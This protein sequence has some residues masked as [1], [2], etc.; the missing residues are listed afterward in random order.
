MIL[1]HRGGVGKTQIREN[2]LQAFDR[3]ME[4]AHIDGI[5]CDLRLTVDGIVVIHHDHRLS[6]GRAIASLEWKELPHYVP[7]LQDLLRRASA[8][9]YKGI[10]NLEIKTYNTL[11][12]VIPIIRK[13]PQIKAS[14]ILLSSF[15]HREIECLPPEIEHMR[16]IIM[17][18]QPYGAFGDFVQNRDIKLILRESAIDWKDPVVSLSLQCMA[19][20]VFLWTVNDAKR[21][22]QLRKRG[23]NII[24]D[25]V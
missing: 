5:E 3:A 14:Q 21:I 10:L 7:T 19:K 16:G 2:T 11:K 25:C 8:R 13:F 20:N 24:T 15:L 6:D 22:T 9:N 23:F 12:L 18:C 17:A 1:A 4:N